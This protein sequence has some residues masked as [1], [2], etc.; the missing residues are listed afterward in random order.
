[1]PETT[2]KVIRGTSLDD[3]FDEWEQ[4]YPLAARQGFHRDGIVSEGQFAREADRLLFVMLE[5]NSQGG[6][7]DRFYGWDL[8]HAIP[9]EVPRKENSKNLARWARLLLDGD[10][11]MHPATVEATRAAL[12]RVAYMNLKKVGGS[13]TASTVDISIQ[14]WHDRDFIRREIKTIRPTIIVTCGDD[15]NRLLGKVLHDDRLW[16]TPQAPTWEWQGALVII[17]NHPSLRPR[18]AAAAF[19]RLRD[20][21]REAGLGAF[22]RGGVA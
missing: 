10:V 15:A 13:G 4:A 17:A 22:G 18:N 1:M 9:M 5:P 6:S 7:Y 12:A 11:Y 2:R 14:A 19:N 8:R 3:L 21:A 16:V 20:R